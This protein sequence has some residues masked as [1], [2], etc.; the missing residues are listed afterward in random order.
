MRIKLTKK[1]S[2]S[3]VRTNRP[4]VHGVGGR[5]KVSEGEVQRQTEKTQARVCWQVFAVCCYL[6]SG[7]WQAVPNTRPQRVAARAEQAPLSA[8]YGHLACTFA[9]T[10]G[11]AANS[12]PSYAVGPRVRPS[13][14]VS[15]HQSAATDSVVVLL[16]RGYLR[17][18]PRR[19]VSP[20]PAAH[21]AHSSV[22][23]LPSL[24][25]KPA[26]HHKGLITHSSSLR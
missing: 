3:T 15:P 23:K 4:V 18:V 14:L 7:G 25:H 1:F 19:N 16:G 21:P 2:L 22:A 8:A 6:A 13:G 10:V 24:P 20:T 11:G 26:P 5:A 12:L 17:S 9:Q